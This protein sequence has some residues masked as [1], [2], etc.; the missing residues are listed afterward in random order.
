M[1]TQHYGL[2]VMTWMS[3]L[4]SSEL[5]LLRI[6]QKIYILRNGLAMWMGPGDCWNTLVTERFELQILCL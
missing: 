1:A 2:A 3:R 6:F 5:R 4:R